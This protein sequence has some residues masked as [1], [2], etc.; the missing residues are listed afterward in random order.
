MLTKR[1]EEIAARK[2]RFAECLDYLERQDGLDI[3]QVAT[4]MQISPTVVKMALRPK[5]LVVSSELI[6]RFCNTYPGLFSYEWIM[7]G[8]GE[9]LIP[10]TLESHPDHP[11]TLARWERLQ[12]IMEHEGLNYVSFSERIGLGSPAMM[13]RILKH[14]TRPQDKT[15]RKVWKAFPRYSYEWLFKGVGR[16]LK[17]TAEEMGKGVKEGNA[18]MCHDVQH[19]AFPIMPDDA[20]AGRLLGYGDPSYDQLQHEEVLVDREYQGEYALFKIK[21]DSMDDGTLHALA[22]GD[23]VLARMIPQHYWQYKLHTH[24][25]RYFIFVTRTEGV[26]VKEIARQNLEKGTITLR[27][28]NKSYPNITI[29]LDDVTA[30]YNVIEV[31]RRSM[32][33]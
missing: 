2:Q 20:R 10:P 30:V 17:P 23:M 9:M 18:T 22:D 1:K 16:P 32:K 33:L 7:N 25:W 5:S 13:F 3:K 27:S 24:A 29:L 11:A 26:I 14:G 4:A 31:T 6:R 8:T 12:Y 15:L 21:G 28:L 19:R